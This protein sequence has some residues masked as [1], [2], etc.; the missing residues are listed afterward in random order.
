MSRRKSKRAKNTRQPVSPP[1]VA[2]TAGKTSTIE[3]TSLALAIKEHGGNVTKIAQHYQ[4]SRQT[5]YD[6][7]SDFEMHAELEAARKQVF[8]AAEDNLISAVYEGDREISKFVVTHFPGG[9]RWSSRQEVSA[10]A[11]QLPPDVAQ[12]VNES[13][14][15]LE[16]IVRAFAEVIREQTEQ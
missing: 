15:S 3:R 9:R 8:S 7:V 16:E 10:T 4:R 6:W 5:I 14:L 13:G 2:L 12:I 11:L 1:P